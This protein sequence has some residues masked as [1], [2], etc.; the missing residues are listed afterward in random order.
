MK[1]L[2]LHVL[3]VSCNQLAMS[4]SRMTVMLYAAYLQASP[5]VI[6]LLAG[7]FGDRKSVV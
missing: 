1:P 4:G 7:L 3:L 5:V 2:H 6:G